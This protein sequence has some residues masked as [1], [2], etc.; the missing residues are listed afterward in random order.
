MKNRISKQAKAIADRHLEALKTGNFD[1]P[2]VHTKQE[3][4]DALRA[5]KTLSGVID[6]IETEFIS[7]GSIMISKIFKHESKSYRA[8]IYKGFKILIDKK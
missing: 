7:V 1:D 3:V 2:V 8:G 4:I 6:Q 5:G